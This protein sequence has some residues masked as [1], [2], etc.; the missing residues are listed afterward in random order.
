MA[1]QSGN[2]RTTNYRVAIPNRRVDLYEFMKEESDLEIE[3]TYNNCVMIRKI[4]M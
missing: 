4:K 2:K 3:I 1:T